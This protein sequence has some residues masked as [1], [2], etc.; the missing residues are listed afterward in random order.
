[1]YTCSYYRRILIQLQNRT[2]PVIKYHHGTCFWYLI[3]V[4]LPFLRQPHCQFLTSLPL[5]SPDVDVIILH[6]FTKCPSKKAVQPK[7][8]LNTNKTEELEGCSLYT[9]NMKSKIF[10]TK[11]SA[12][13][14]S[15]VTH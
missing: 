5:A 12:F 6:F 7:L 11:L 10:L 3:T 2:M 15:M 14:A 4:G 9:L 1:M 13:K 8:V